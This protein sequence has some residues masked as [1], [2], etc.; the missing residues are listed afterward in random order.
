LRR[1]RPADHAL[2]HPAGGDG[3][4][5]GR[6]DR[7]APRGSRA[8]RSISSARSVPVRGDA[9]LRAPTSM[10]RASA[11][12]TTAGR[13]PKPSRSRPSSTRCGRPQRAG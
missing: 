5:V 10:R 11:A 7:A 8:P 3:R 2:S 1:E 13:G 12:S 4:L 9:S 6:A